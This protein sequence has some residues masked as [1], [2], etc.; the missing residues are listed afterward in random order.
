MWQ[1]LLEII[2]V[3]FIFILHLKHFTNLL[4]NVNWIKIN[5]FLTKS[6]NCSLFLES[7]GTQVETEAYIFKQIFLNAVA[8]RLCLY[9]GFNPCSVYKITVHKEAR[10]YETPCT[11]VIPSLKHF[12]YLP[13]NFSCQRASFK[14][15]YDYFWVMFFDQKSGKIDQNSKI[16]SP[17][18]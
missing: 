6:A 8:I 2:A 14:H 7:T 3:I 4:S 16:L 15:P 17:S 9:G 5:N 11:R 1:T 10:W 13:L 12:P 18:S